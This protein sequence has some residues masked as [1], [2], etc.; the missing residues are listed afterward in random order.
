MIT[1]DPSVLDS[2]CQ[3]ISPAFVF[4]ILLC[5]SVPPSMIPEGTLMNALLHSLS[6]EKRHT[7][8]SFMFLSC[9]LYPTLHFYA[10]GIQALEPKMAARTEE[11]NRGHEREAMT[12]S[13][14]P[15]FICKM[16]ELSLFFQGTQ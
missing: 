9:E 6:W 10:S 11:S 14:I 1:C 13:F 2:I 4:A 3:H 16:R 15:L 12:T 5:I 7:S 8:H